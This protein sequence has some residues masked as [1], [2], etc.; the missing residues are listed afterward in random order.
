MSSLGPTESIHNRIH[1]NVNDGASGLG[2]GLLQKANDNIIASSD[3]N[4]GVAL[5]DIAISQVIDEI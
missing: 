2:V 4:A 5:P 3:S 1:R